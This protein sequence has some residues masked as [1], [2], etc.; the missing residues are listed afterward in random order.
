MGWKRIAEATAWGGAVFLGLWT[1]QFYHKQ[2]SFAAS[3]GP[4][5]RQT[6]QADKSQRAPS[7]SI[8]PGQPILIR[9]ATVWTA[10][11]RTHSRADVLIKKGKIAAIGTKLSAKGAAIVDGTGKYLTP[12]LIDTHSHM[13]V[14]PSVGLRAT[15]DGNE[16]VRPV[17]A[18]AWAEH[19]I[20]TQDP[21]IPK[22]VAGGTTTAQILPG[23]GNLIGGRGVTIKLKMA[24]SVAKMKFP[25]APHGLKMACGEN[26]KRVHR[27]VMTRMGSFA[28]YRRAFLQA[29]AYRQRW[30]RYEKAL[31]KWKKARASQPAPASQPTKSKAKKKAV[32]QAKKKPR[33]PKKNL[34]L[35]TLK[36]VLDGKIL[37]H[38]HCYRA[39]EMLWMIKLSK[40]FGFRIRSFHHAVEAYK[41]RDVLAKESIS[42]STWADWWGF[43]LEAFDGIQENAALIS[44]VGGR[45]I[46]HSDSAIGIQRLNQ[47]AAK[48]Y[49]RGKAMGLKLTEEE[50]IRWITIHPAWALGIDKQTGSIEVGKMA[51]LVLWSGH[52]F[53]VY[54]RASNVFIDGKLVHDSRWPPVKT[55]FE[56][57]LLMRSPTK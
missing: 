12:G 47:E 30:Q 8:S 3:S 15:A 46:I 29:Q 19:A 7:V 49:Y 34:N 35:E 22:A 9:G 4:S 51:D 43:K 18:Y 56:L 37:V 33:A 13:G 11:G 28:G 26:P 10:T 1:I 17:T 25:G 55:D 20:W 32:K 31:A 16:M 53:S 41:I 2:L 14:Y 39:E 57:G 50:A 54:S 40:E 23:S 38:I 48:A 42:V 44:A 24:R 36:L 45:A 27:S 6:K 5:S 52:P 21:A